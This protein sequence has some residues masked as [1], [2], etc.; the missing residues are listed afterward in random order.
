MTK[1]LE[2]YST[3]A[4]LGPDGCDPTS[5][6]LGHELKAVIRAGIGRNPPD[7]EKIPQDIDDIGGVEIAFHPNCQTLSR[8]L[9]NL[10][11]NA[12]QG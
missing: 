10:T 2:H 12:A 7:A 9:I 11:A 1:G 3:E 4:L 5:D 6:G 8:G